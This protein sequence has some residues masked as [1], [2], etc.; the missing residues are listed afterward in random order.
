MRLEQCAN[1]DFTMVSPFLDY[2]RIFYYLKESNIDITVK[3]TIESPEGAWYPVQV[4]YFDKNVDYFALMN[5]LVFKNKLKLIFFYHEADDPRIISRR[6][7]QLCDD[8]NY[9][10]VAFVSGNSVAGDYKYCYYWPEIEYMYQRT[11]DFSKA[12]LTHFKRRSKHFMAL[13]RIDK[14]ER[15][16]FMSNLWKNG[17]DKHGY[18][19]YCQEQLNQHND[20]A[21]IDLYDEF[22]AEQEQLGQEFIKA[23]PFYVDNLTSEQ[24]NNYS[25]LTDDMYQ[26]SYF[27]FVLESFICID[28]SGGQSIT[29]K[30]WKPILHCQP[31]ICLAEHHHLRHLREL[32]YHTFD[33]IIDAKLFASK[34][35]SEGIQ[36]YFENENLINLDPLLSNALGGIRLKVSESDFLQAQKVLVEYSQIALEGDDGKPLECPKCKS[37]KIKNGVKD[38]TGFR[39]IVSFILALTFFIVPLSHKSK[40]R[41]K[42]CEHL[43]SFKSR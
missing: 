16:I 39:G 2:P 32:G 22:L 40:Y 15:R 1:D 19:S 14:P 8:Y 42:N 34:L 12:S 18:F 38:F 36:T 29:E 7:K 33:N 25:V 41:C 26:D 23:G 4:S 43:F 11:V 21:G 13:C 27:N 37:I 6:I 30:T 5:P 10:N 28:G 24:R 9:H 20:Y 3:H 35:E 17:L 31:F